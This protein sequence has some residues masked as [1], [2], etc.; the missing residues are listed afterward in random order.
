MHEE[1]ILLHQGLL[2]PQRAHYVWQCTA[3]LA[4]KDYWQVD[5]MTV[6]FVA[7][8]GTGNL[9]NFNVGSSVDLTVPRVLPLSICHIPDTATFL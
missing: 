6:V 1:R 7:D 3:G 8:G 9:C 2:R 5:D 4:I